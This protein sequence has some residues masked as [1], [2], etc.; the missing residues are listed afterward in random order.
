MTL[1]HS[2]EIVL[3][4]FGDY[5]KGKRHKCITSWERVRLYMEFTIGFYPYIALNQD[6]IRNYPNGLRKRIHS[7]VL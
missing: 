2:S 3:C 1:K 4:H 6:Y 7:M 5:V